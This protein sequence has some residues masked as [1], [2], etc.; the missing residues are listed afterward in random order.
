MWARNSLCSFVYLYSLKDDIQGSASWFIKQGKGIIFQ[1]CASRKHAVWWCFWAI[2]E[3]QDFLSLP[4]AEECS[5]L[6]KIRQLFN[7]KSKNVLEG[8]VFH[9]SIWRWKTEESLCFIVLSALHHKDAVSGSTW[10]SRMFLGLS[11]SVCSG[12]I[13]TEMPWCWWGV[14]HLFVCARTG[15]ILLDFVTGKLLWCHLRKLMKTL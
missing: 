13:H 2:S 11:K 8:L 4:W 5:G 9:S 7:H 12:Y 1:A 15:I 3:L 14:L 10:S 6:T